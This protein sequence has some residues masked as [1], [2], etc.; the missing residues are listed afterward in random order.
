MSFTKVVRIGMSRPPHAKRGYSIFCK[1]KF[2]EDGNLSISGVEGPTAS[3]NARGGCGQINMHAWYIDAYAPGWSRDLMMKFKKVWKQYHLNDM[4]AGTPAQTEVLTRRKDE[5]TGYPLSYY[6]WALGVLA[7]E[8]L[9]ID[10]GYK[11]G[12]KWLRI[13]VP[14]EVQEF[15]Q[16]LPDTDKTPA[17]V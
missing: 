2:N 7:E 4:Q 10:N 3:G 5:Y 17:W 12:S 8:G 11:Y 6:D 16:S 1:I 14:T 15:L 13:D 9:D